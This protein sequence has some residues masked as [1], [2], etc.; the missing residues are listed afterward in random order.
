MAEPPPW[1]VAAEVIRC[2]SMNGRMPRTSTAV[3]HWSRNC[4]GPP[5]WLRS[6]AWRW[7][8]GQWRVVSLTTAAA[9]PATAAVTPAPS[10]VPAE[11]P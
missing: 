11:V 10:A 3:S 7:A 2:W 6:A 4:S 5:G 8:A 1:R 9:D